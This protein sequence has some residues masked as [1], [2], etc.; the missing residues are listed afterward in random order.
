MKNIS[1]IIWLNI[2]V[3]K[4]YITNLPSLSCNESS[5]VFGIDDGG[6]SKILLLLLHWLKYKQRDSK[7]VEW[8]IQHQFK[9]TNEQHDK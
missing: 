9:Q 3:K 7:T 6:T 4:K 1:D 2:C 8:D 5:E